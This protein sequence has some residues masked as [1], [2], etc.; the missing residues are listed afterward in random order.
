M[1]KVIDSIKNIGAKVVSKITDTM[2]TQAEANA[3]EDKLNYWRK[4]LARN[5]VEFN[6]GMM[7]EREYIYL[8]SH[9]V[10]GN[11]TTN[12]RPTKDANTVYNIAFEF[13]ETQIN[14]NVPQPSVKSIREGFEEQAHMIEDSITDKLKQ[15]DTEEVVDAAERITAVQGYSIM[16]LC[17]NNE[18]H[19]H[20]YSGDMELY[21]RHP[22]QFIPQTGVFKLKNMDYFFVLSKVTKE[23]VKKRY[24]KDLDY[25][26]E[27]YPDNT[28]LSGVSQQG[29]MSTPDFALTECV[30]WYKDDDGD[31]CKYT[32]VNTTELEDLPKYYYRRDENGQIMTTETLT[33]DVQIGSTQVVMDPQTGQPTEQPITLPAGTEIPLYIPE[34][35]PFIVRKNVPKNFSFGGQSDLDVTRDHQDTMKKVVSKMEERIIKGGSIVKVLEDHNVTITDQ[36]NQVIKGNAQQLSVLGV[37]NLQADIQADIEYIQVIYKQAQSMLGITD[38]FQGKEDSSAKSGVAKQ[39]QVQQASGRLLSKAFNKNAAFKELYQLMFEFMLAFYDEPRPFLSTDEFG[40]PKYQE[41]DKY[42]FL[43]VDDAGEYYYNTDFLFSADPGDHLPQDR[44]FMFNTAKEL[45]QTGA[46][47]Q[48][49]FWQILEGL[50]FP[51]AK[52][53]LSQLEERQQQQ[54]LMQQQQMQMQ[55]Q[56]AQSQAQGNVA[57]QMSFNDHLMN[58]A[59]EHQQMFNALPQHEKVA[60]QSA[61]QSGMGVGP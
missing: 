18:Y 1:A 9:G 43:M 33:R 14:L 27:Q 36:I 40:K 32:W 39:I 38:S 13:I 59:P 21:N 5:Q 29:D 12:Q 19:H 37:E 42:K 47:D 35:M 34:C 3:V 25:Q 11:I 58:M 23:Y 24:G 56:Q 46:V 17:W 52:Q 30:A 60:I 55:A 44:V 51:Q 2:D 8:G 7:D 4:K 57:P 16:E 54:A 41:F 48:M 10:D 45:L 61:L 15:M 26:T 22:K 53:I 49:Q 50:G 28:N 31:V 20:L 6:I